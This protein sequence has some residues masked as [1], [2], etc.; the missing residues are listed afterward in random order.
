MP[1]AAKVLPTQGP[2]DEQLQHRKD[3]S[4]EDSEDSHGHQGN[5]SNP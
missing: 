3:L 1:N 5:I 4:T 2:E